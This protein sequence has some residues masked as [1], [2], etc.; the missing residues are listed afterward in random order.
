MKKRDYLVWSIL[1]TLFCCV[2]FG[3]VSIVY[4]AKANSAYD[5]GNFDEHSRCA[6]KA[7][8]WMILGAVLGLISIVLY[9]VIQGVGVYCALNA[10][11][12]MM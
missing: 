1:T 7:K 10:E 11:Q 3:I 2:P 4:A 6:D 12:A 9:A 8:I 5:A